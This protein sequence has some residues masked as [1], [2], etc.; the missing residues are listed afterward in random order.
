[1]FK[2]FTSYTETEFHTWKFKTAMHSNLSGSCIH[3]KSQD[4]GI[5]RVWCASDGVL[6]MLYEC[7]AL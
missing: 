5:I 1:M 4:T 3:F 6:N 2:V 7:G